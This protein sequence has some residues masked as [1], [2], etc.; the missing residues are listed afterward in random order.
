[1]N[2]IYIARHGQDMDNANKIL[3]G[4][5]NMPLSDIG[6]QQAHQ[7][8]EMI[9]DSWIVFDKVYS[10]PL[11]RAY[12]TAI[13]IT[14][15][16]WLDDPEKLDILIE[17]DFGIMT[18][19]PQQ[20]IELLCSP[21]I[22][23]THTV[24]YFLSP[25]GAETFPQLMERAEKILEYINAKHH[26]QTIL[27]VAHGDLGKMIYATYY[28]VDWQDVLTMFHFGNSELLLLSEDT[29]KEHAHVFITKQHN[30]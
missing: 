24:T 27:L 7:L 15:L 17:R 5:R 19:K 1:M 2:T 28:H 20:D 13:T 11:T 21:D 29:T 18:G 22:I 3:N 16:M 23:K 6:L 10:S 9:R 12:T 26:Q 30:I 14:N 4:H 8:A 25:E